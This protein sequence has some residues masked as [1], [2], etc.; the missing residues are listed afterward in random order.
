MVCPKADLNTQSQTVLTGWLVLMN[1]KTLRRENGAFVGT[2]GISENNTASGFRPAFFHE[3]SGKVEISRL[4]NG[5]LAPIH[6]VDW[7]PKDWAISFH[8]DGRVKCLGAGIVA[9]FVRN[10]V[11]YTRKEVADLIG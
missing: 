10:T 11:F 1:S 3:N 4:A 7:L 5:Q 6:I 2:A 9:G 8:E